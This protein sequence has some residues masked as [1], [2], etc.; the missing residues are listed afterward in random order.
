MFRPFPT[1]GACTCEL[2][3]SKTSLAWSQREH[4][5]YKIHVQEISVTKH[6]PVSSPTNAGKLG[7]TRTTAFV[8]GCGMNNPMVWAS[9]TLCI[10]FS[11]LLSYDTRH[12]FFFVKRVSMGGLELPVCV[13]LLSC[14]RAVAALPCSNLNVESICTERDQKWSR[15]ST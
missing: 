15:L 4:G 7:A 9:A 11:L 13:W 5:S 6:W 3:T 8:R 2:Y 1:V 10:Y 12:T 14:L